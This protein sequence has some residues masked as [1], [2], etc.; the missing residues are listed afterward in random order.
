MPNK[1]TVQIVNAFTDAGEGGNPAGVVYPA[2]ELSNEIKQAIA[3]KVGIS[4][5]SFVSKSHTADFKL[6]FFTPNRQIPHCGHATIATFSYLSQQGV[7]QGPKSSKETIDGNRDIFLEG[8][9]AYM[10]QLAPRYFPLPYEG[11][12]EQDV[13]DSLRI[14]KTDLLDEYEPMPVNTGNYF[15]MIPIKNE[16]TLKAIKPDLK[17]IDEISETLD[18]IGYYPFTLETKVKGRDAGAR[19]F[20]PYYSILE[21]AATG[22]AAGPLA[23]YLFD[24]MNIQKENMV[25]EQGRLMPAPSPSEILVELKLEDRNISGLL[26]GGRAKVT[27]SIEVELD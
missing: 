9:V 5:I 26:A 4:E 20:A 6:E 23:C 15:M 18:L 27:H 8:D 2:D 7:V 14:L 12:T 11:V 16:R 21:E 1:I 13:L 10:Q 17:A 25:I 3:T 24:K 19:M 22:M